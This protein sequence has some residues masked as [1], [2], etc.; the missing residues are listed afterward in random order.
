MGIDSDLELLRNGLSCIEDAAGKLRSLLPMMES[1]AAGNACSRFFNEYFREQHAR[2]GALG[3]IGNT[4]QIFE[5]NGY[6]VAL[7]IEVVGRTR[8]R[9][10]CSVPQDMI[11]ALLSD[12]SV[13]LEVFRSSDEVPDVFREGSAVGHH[14][15]RVLHRGDALFIDGARD[16]V[17]T[18]SDTPYVSLVVT[19]QTMA[20]HLAARHD[21]TTGVAL[22]AT[23]ATQ[24]LSRLHHACDY[25]AHFGDAALA[26]PLR[27]LVLHPAH[28]IRWKAAEA[29]LNVDFNAGLRTI[30]QMRS[31][32]HPH[33]AD[34]AR[35]AWTQ[36]QHAS[37]PTCH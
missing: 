27:Q 22:Y 15:T 2:R 1:L 37:L 34:A 8:P 30:F 21:S 18:W 20:R 24:H 12:C 6:S 5:E 33:I 3:G 23:A 4:L 31:D 7:G 35:Q 10:V 17:L 36:L 32:P 16:H 26:S 28:F 14:C 25:I 19:R 29:L 11:V 9:E 13:Q